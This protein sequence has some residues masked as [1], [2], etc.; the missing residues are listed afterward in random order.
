MPEQTPPKVPEAC[1]PTAHPVPEPAHVL[2]RMA[3]RGETWQRRLTKNPITIWVVFLFALAVGIN[4][5][6]TMLKDTTPAAPQCG[7]HQF[8]IP[9]SKWNTGEGVSYSCGG[10]V[11]SVIVSTAPAPEGKRKRMIHVR[12]EPKGGAP[13]DCDW[14]SCLDGKS[15][16]AMV[17]GCSIVQGITSL[18]CSRAD[19]VRMED[20]K[21]TRLNS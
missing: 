4:Q 8:R 16:A 14:Y 18:D 20:R 17:S 3:A 9:A 6:R 10:A 15:K 13:I 5:V 21:S 7:L 1:A 12:A 2:D 19:E 11:Y